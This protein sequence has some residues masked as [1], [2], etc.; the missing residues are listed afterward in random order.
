MKYDCP[1]CEDALAERQRII[2][3]TEPRSAT[4]QQALDAAMTERMLRE[5]YELALRE[6][7]LHLNAGNLI[8]AR[9][10]IAEALRP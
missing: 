4:E 10:T 6:A 8:L 2:Q 3:V 7:Y 5:Q 9:Y 1:I